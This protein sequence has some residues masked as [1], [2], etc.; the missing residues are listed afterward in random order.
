MSRASNFV[1]S[2]PIKY[3]K[4]SYH[5]YSFRDSSYIWP[6]ASTWCIHK[7]HTEFPNAY[8]P[9]L[10]STCKCHQLLIIIFSFFFTLLF[11]CLL[12]NCLP[13]GIIDF[14]LRHLVVFRKS[15]LLMKTTYVVVVLIY[16]SLCFHFILNLV[17]KVYFRTPHHTWIYFFIIK[18]Y[19]H[20]SQKYTKEV[21]Q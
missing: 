19:I 15:R 12:F 13:D 18:K 1:F 16:I 9:P 14:V 6:Y 5:V 21:Y 7:T 20:D 11:V 2:F 8:H 3:F 17:A 4:C 10:F